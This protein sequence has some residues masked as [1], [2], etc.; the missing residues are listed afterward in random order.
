[1]IVR[2]SPNFD[3]RPEGTPVNMLVLHY[4]GMPTAGA[5]LER[6][7][8]PAA[9]VSAH[10][11]IDED[12][13][14]F[15]LVD[16]GSRAWHAGRSAWRGLT[17][18]NSRSIG[19]ELVNPGHEFG[20]RPFPQPQMAALAELALDLLA[21]HPIPPRNVVAHAD[22]AP[23]RKEDPGELFD[24]RSLAARGIGIWP[25]VLHA[26]ATVADVADLLGRWGYDVTD[27]KAALVAFQRHFRPARFDGLADRETVTLLQALLAM[28]DER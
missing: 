7:G 17:D 26:P 19:I 16:E 13:R 25:E 24:W 14:V 8:D 2:P 6:L 3:A 4:T 9:K 15:A 23:T 28:A 18:V 5:A 1:M 12:G 27:D 20:Y 21:R 10:Y 22:V 11:L